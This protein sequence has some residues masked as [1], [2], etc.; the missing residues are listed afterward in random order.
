MI[1]LVSE[2][3][4]RRKKIVIGILEQHPE[5]LLLSEVSTFVKD[6]S[7]G[8]NG[9][10]FQDFGENNLRQIL[11]AVPEIT[12]VGSSHPSYTIKKID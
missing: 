4:L 8:G 11:K 2:I 7:F 9:T 1:F 12:R 10:L 6:V 3:T 5:G